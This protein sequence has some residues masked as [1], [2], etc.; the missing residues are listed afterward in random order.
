MRDHDALR[1]ARRRLVGP[2]R[3][4]VRTLDADSRK[5]SKTE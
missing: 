3:T 4:A 2:R 5:L 1:G